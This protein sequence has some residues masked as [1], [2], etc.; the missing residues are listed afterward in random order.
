MYKYTHKLLPASFENI[1]KS[2]ETLKDLLTINLTFS[3]CA[4]YSIYQQALFL[5]C[6]IT[7]LLT[8]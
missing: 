8:L 4:H 3:K 1:F 5:R 2:L 6:R 7:C